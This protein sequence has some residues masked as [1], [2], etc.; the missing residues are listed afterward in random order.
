MVQKY[1]LIRVCFLVYLF[2]I[3]LWVMNSKCVENTVYN[4]YF[5]R[6]KINIK[7]DIIFRNLKKK[8]SL[9]TIIYLVMKF[10][11]SVS[12]CLN[13]VHLFAP[14]PNLE[15]EQNI[16]SN[17]FFNNFHLSES[18]FTCPGLRASGLERRLGF[19]QILNSFSEDVY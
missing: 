19:L 18:S 5:K 6:S 14:K 17:R 1:S 10:V 4:V 15:E 12:L 3:V 13:F 8:N 9:Q 2:R 11:Y 16:Y 7:L